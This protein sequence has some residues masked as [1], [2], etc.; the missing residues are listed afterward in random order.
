MTKEHIL[1]K[2]GSGGTDIVELTVTMTSNTTPSGYRAYSYA[3]TTGY[4]AYR[5]FDGTDRWVTYF[6]S[7][8][9]S[10]NYLAYQFPSA[11]TV[12]QMVVLIRNS[13]TY[14]IEACNNGNWSDAVKLGTLTPTSSSSD[15]L[16]I[17]PL[18][19]DTAYTDYRLKWV[20]GNNSIGI[21][22]VYMQG[23]K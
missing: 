17:I 19:N 21:Y 18:D 13:N 12:K 22:K 3:E 7:S 8:T 5:A 23:I 9:G 11:V 14:D 4:E 20:S 16:K 10:G 6:A 2:V 15:Q 1:G